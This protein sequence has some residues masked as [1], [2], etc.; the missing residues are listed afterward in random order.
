MVGYC[1]NV[2]FFV[3]SGLIG[4]IDIKGKM[5]KMV[6][7]NQSVID[8]FDETANKY[9][10]RK[11]LIMVNGKEMTFAEVSQKHYI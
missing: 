1:V 4:L 2:C 7:Q 3:Y 10:N 6:N 8:I 5:R 11:A 9:P